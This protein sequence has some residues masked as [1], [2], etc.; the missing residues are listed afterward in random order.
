M[1]ESFD[2]VNP[3]TGE[4]TAAPIM[5]DKKVVE[6]E[7]RDGQNIKLSFDIVKDF[8]VNGKRELVTQQE[9]T[10]FMALC[11]SRGLNPFINDA[12]LIKYS[13]NEKAAIV[14]SIDYFR[15]RARAQPDCKG[16]AKGVICLKKDG[17]LRYSN[18]LILDDEKLVGGWFEATPA[19]WDRPFQLEVNLSGYLKRTKEGWLTAFW[20]EEKQATQIAKVAES[21]GLRT[22]WPDEFQQLYTK[23][24][25]PPPSEAINMAMVPQRKQL[26]SE[27][28][29]K[30]ENRAAAINATLE[31]PPPDKENPPLKSEPEMPS[32]GPPKDSGDQIMKISDP[33]PADIA[34]NQKTW[35]ELTALCEQKGAKRAAVVKSRAVKTINEKGKIAP[36]GYRMHLPQDAAEELI[37][38]LKTRPDVPTIAPEEDNSPQAEEEQTAGATDNQEDL[39]VEQVMGMVDGN[40]IKWCT[41][42]SAECLGRVRRYV[43]RGKINTKKKAE[44]MV[45]FA[46]EDWNGF[47][48]LIKAEE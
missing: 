10:F 32:P 26:A 12:Y 47:L 36:T 33:L 23:E 11:K 16:W 37:A 48:K 31:T 41:M 5:M 3:Y 24:E 29:E 35:K 19:G 44:A 15:K 8:L 46:R 17:T 39:T 4:V 45:D 25:M 14:T 18:G 21:Q 30:H 40:F 22:V 1:K 27:V 2:D 28:I 20:S 9:L 42:E 13:A 38:E 6:Y 43:E 34:C 7:A